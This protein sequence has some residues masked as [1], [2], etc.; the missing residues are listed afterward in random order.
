MPQFFLRHQAQNDKNF[1]FEL[2]LDIES[3]PEFLPACQDC[4]IIERKDKELTAR[5]TL[6]YGRL[7][8]TFVSLVK[9]DRENHTIHATLQEG[10]LKSLNCFWEFIE[11]E[12][13]TEIKCS[14][15]FEFHSGLLKALATPLLDHAAKRLIES[16]IERAQALTPEQQ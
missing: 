16:F 1:L 7:H 2:V 8:E 3:Y 12:Q 14:L 13:G 6:G 15:A 10:R 9:F 5:L 11:T 4:T